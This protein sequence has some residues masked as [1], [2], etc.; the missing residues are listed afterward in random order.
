MRKQQ[1][2]L[3]FVLNQDGLQHVFVKRNEHLP[4][5]EEFQNLLMKREEFDRILDLAKSRCAK[6]RC[7]ETDRQATGIRF[8]GNK[9]LTCWHLKE[10]YGKTIFVN[11][12]QAE[13]L[14]E[15]KELDLLLLK[16]DNT[17]LP[18]LQ[19]GQPGE[20]DPVFWVG[21]PL[22][23]GRMITQCSVMAVR[24]KKFYVSQQIHL[25]ASG[26][27]VYLYTGELV[28]MIY[29]YY[30]TPEEGTISCARTASEIKKFIDEEPL[31]FCLT[32]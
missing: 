18:D 6:L 25:G 19:F 22:G 29:Q 13:V 4:S 32:G 31:Q 3:P 27:G 30:G 26:S 5:S 15:S 28:G 23:K 10:A 20:L 11:G 8:G 14:H 9:V 16:S 17:N 7:P 12:K 24:K 1:P 21:H 2:K